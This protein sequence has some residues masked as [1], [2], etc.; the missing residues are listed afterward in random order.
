M[1]NK[2]KQSIDNM[3]VAGNTPRDTK[4]GS[5]ILGVGARY[6]QLVGTTGEKTRLGEYYET[7]TGQELPVGG[8]D[9]RQAHI[10]KGIR[11]T[12]KCA[13]AKRK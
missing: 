8:F 13:T 3:I 11:N 9:P 4:G 6:H 1:S 12:S 7:K 5:V 10:D 2:L